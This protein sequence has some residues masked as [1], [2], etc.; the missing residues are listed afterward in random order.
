MES[1]QPKPSRSSDPSGDQLLFTVRAVATMTSLDPR[2]AVGPPPGMR[3][4]L[5]SNESWFGPF[6]EAIVAGTEA[7]R[8]AD[9]YPD[10]QARELTRAIANHIGCGVD[11]LTIGAGSTTLL[12]HLI[13]QQC[14]SFESPGEATTVVAYEYAFNGYRFA[15]DAVGAR[16]AEAPITSGLQRDPQALLQTV[17]NDCAV[18]AVDNPGNP[19]GQALFGDDLEFLIRHLPPKV[20][21][22]VDEAYL[23]YAEAHSRQFRSGTAFLDIH[24]RV[25]VLRT[26]SKVYGLAGLRVGYAI[27][28]PDVIAWLERHRPRVNVSAPAQAAAAAS[29]PRGDLAAHIVERT[30]TSKDATVAGLRELGADLVRGLGN[31]ILIQSLP[32]ASTTVG[33]FAELGVGVRD[34][35]PY[36]LP[37]SIRVTIGREGHMHEFLEAANHVLPSGLSGASSTTRYS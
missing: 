24:P 37:H 28:K 20:M 35:T 4:R 3:V 8:G 12:F 14:R 34:M 6:P 5:S 22:I 19:T 30:M 1:T 7:V 2:H 33:R 27:A 16:Y 32:S 25:V 17:T 9:L 13:Q 10:D 26:F 11:N 21:V 18:V 15:A 23:E 29:L 31:F 36:S